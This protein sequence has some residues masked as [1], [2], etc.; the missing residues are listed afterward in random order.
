M[1]TRILIIGNTTE[2]HHLGSI[3][4]R[5]AQA[6]NLSFM[7]S[8]TSWSYYAPSMKHLWGKAFF[9]LADKRP[10]E[11][12]T[13]NYKIAKLIESYCPQLV[14][15]TG[16]FPLKKEV[17]NACNLVKSKIINYLT[18]SPWSKQNSCAKFSNSLP[19]FDCIF[20]TKKNLIP[21]LIN[22]GVKQVHF[23]PFGFDQCI[24]RCLLSEESGQKNSLFPDVC[25]IGGSD[26]DRIALMT[27]FLINFK[28]KLG[29]YGGYWNKDQKLK[30]YY[31][32]MVLGDNFCRVVRNCKINIGVVRR[33]NGDE[34]SMRSY[35]IPACG[36]VG[37][38]EDTSE[39][40]D[41]FAGYP[42]YGFFTSPKDLADK[43][44][45]LLEH[46]IERE[47]MRQL[48]IQLIVTE[49]N[50]YTARLKTI[51]EWVSK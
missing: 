34:H 17:F 18:D 40:R 28:G 31:Q 25:L 41:L 21:E 19:S 50:T 8:D 33:A 26:I 32:G 43:C 23:L 47:Q 24:H 42:E 44:N 16:I 27:S 5:S 20:S 15:V 12:W 36:G 9:K 37:I 39:H 51:L 35:E 29:L 10:L 1:S 4:A 49:A 45:W 3:F 46:P 22:I 14:L 48:G 38:Y 30:Q 11:W 6:M 13:F 7:T 2:V